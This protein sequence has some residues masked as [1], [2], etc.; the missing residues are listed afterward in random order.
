MTNRTRLAESEI[1]INT[2]V[3]VT[4]RDGITDVTIHGHDFYELEIIA[5]GEIRTV[6]NGHELL[7]TRGDVFLMTP[8]D[9]HEYSGG[10][11]A[12]IYKLQFNG[13]AIPDALR[14][15]IID[16]KSRRLHPS[17][18]VLSETVSLL[19]AMQGEAVRRSA[20]ISARL[21][22]CVLLLVTE[23]SAES[24]PKRTGEADMQRA[25]FYIHEHFKENPTLSEVAA[26]IPLDPRYFCRRFKEH[27]GKTY[28]EYLTGLK[29]RYARRL[30]L[31]T[32]L[33]VLRIAESAGFGAQSHFNKEFK[34]EFGVSPLRMRRDTSGGKGAPKQ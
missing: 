9:L 16:M 12:S 26:L 32:D 4:L 19:A 2:S 1:D 3:S 20:V 5:E 18:E 14:M 7:A 22:E 21:L 29:L 6:Y 25:L 24:E 34:R 33:S 17:D 28:K 23:E 10:V 27:T 31:A 13:D 8:Q 11:G 15:K 30:L